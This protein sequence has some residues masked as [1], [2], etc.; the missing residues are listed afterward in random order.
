M[1]CSKNVFIN[2]LMRF[3]KILCSVFDW[4]CAAILIVMIGAMFLQVAVRF[5]F[6]E[7]NVPWTDELSRYM[8]I[9]IT[10][11]GAGIAI[12]ENAH[13]EISLVT[14][15]IAGAK[16]V[17]ARRRWARV[18]DIIRFALIL[19]ISCFL[20]YYSWVYMLQVKRINMLSAA[21]QIPTWWLDAVLVVGLASMAL[22]SLIRLVI[23]IVDDSVIVDPMCLG[24]EGQE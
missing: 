18:I 10:Y 20:L 6:T 14:A 4:I 1:E 9:S 5:V 24:E 3:E 19:A 22:H 7:M 8:W 11:I 15:M 16:T 23:S 21:M 13:V 2:R 17:E 12:S